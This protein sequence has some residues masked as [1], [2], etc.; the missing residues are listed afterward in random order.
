VRT[1]RGWS[2]FKGEQGG[3]EGVSLRAKAKGSRYGQDVRPSTV[4]AP[5]GE[6]RGR[7]VMAHARTARGAREVV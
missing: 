3:G 4:V 2:A 1:G 5:L 6:R 7:C